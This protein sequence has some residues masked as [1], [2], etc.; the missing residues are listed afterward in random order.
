MSCWSSP[1]DTG[2]LVHQVEA[3]I[4]PR[5]RAASAHL[6]ASG[7]MHWHPVP[8]LELEGAT[9]SEARLGERECG[10]LGMLFRECCEQVF[11]RPVLLAVERA[12]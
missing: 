9:G 1:L 4:E 10:F 5:D 2:E 3:S 8:R 7:Y 11:E 6:W 12:P